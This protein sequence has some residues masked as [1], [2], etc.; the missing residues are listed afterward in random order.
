MPLGFLKPQPQPQRAVEANQLST[1]PL[2]I[3]TSNPLP[4]VIK[5]ADN[6]TVDA[7]SGNKITDKNKLN[8]T[9]DTGLLKEI[10][11]QAKIKGID[12]NTALAMAHQE[13][14]YGSSSDSRPDNPFQISQNYDDNYHEK[15]I[16]NDGD[17]IAMFMDMLKDKINHAKNNLGK[18]NEPDLIQS[19]N[20]YGVISPKSEDNT[21]T[22]YGMNVGS[23]PLNMNKNPVYGKRVIDIRENIIKK[24]PDLQ[25]LVRETPGI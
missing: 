6:R 20:G 21:N 7:A 3:Y 10:I 24:N 17:H 4:D 11:R 25:K 8:Y 19:W 5:I 14:G 23:K 12:P 15:F 22:Y 9:A 18:T 2:K 1:L 16:K 13:S